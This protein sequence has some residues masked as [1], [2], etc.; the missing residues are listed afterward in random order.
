MKH[1]SASPFFIILSNKSQNMKKC[2]KNTDRNVSKIKS[3]I[4]IADMT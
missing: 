2:L 3:T 4:K 1:H